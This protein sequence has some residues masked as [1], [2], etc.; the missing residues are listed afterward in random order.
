MI[1]WFDFWTV[2]LIIATVLLLFWCTY[3]YMLFFL[4]QMRNTNRIS[5]NAT[6]WNIYAHI[7]IVNASKLLQDG[8]QGWQHQQNS[9]Q[10]FADE[11]AR[12]SSER[13]RTSSGYRSQGKPWGDKLICFTQSTMTCFFSSN[14][15]SKCCLTFWVEDL[16]SFNLK[17]GSVSRRLHEIWTVFNLVSSQ[18][19]A[20]MLLLLC[21]GWMSTTEYEIYM[22]QRVL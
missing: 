15:F 4:Q 2:K 5:L 8:E 6:E 7:I 17:I 21:A 19:H 13:R 14:C 22:V 16:E 3:M 10:H 9:P 12:F 11:L 20:A 1:P 18:F